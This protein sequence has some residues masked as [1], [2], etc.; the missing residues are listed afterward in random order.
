MACLFL[1]WKTQ[2]FS[3]GWSNS[4]GATDKKMDGSVLEEKSSFQMLGCLFLLNWTGI[5]TLSLLLELAP[6]K[7]DS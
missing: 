5:L 7:L 4:I 2:L 3:F 1:C 6:R